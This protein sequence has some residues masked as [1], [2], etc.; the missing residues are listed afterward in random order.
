MLGTFI[1]QILE[2]PHHAKELREWVI[3]EWAD[4]NSKPLWHELRKAVLD[5]FARFKRVTVI[6]DALDELSPQSQHDVG[7]VISEILSSHACEVKVF[8]SCRF[9]AIIMSKIPQPQFS[10]AL[11]P[12]LLS[13]DIHRFVEDMVQ[14]KIDRKNLTIQD[15]ALQQEINTKL[16]EGAQ[17]MY[18]Y[19]RIHG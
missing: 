19:C 6:L 4:R 1:R 14:E 16:Q 12:R 2:G 8:L 3:K 15:P 17:D 5:A 18:V 7:S 9:E 10:I 13:M 11:S